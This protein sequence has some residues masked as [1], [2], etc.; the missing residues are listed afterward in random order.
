VP[1]AGSIHHDLAG[2]VAAAAAPATVAPII[3]APARTAPIVLNFI[4]F[5]LLIG[6]NLISQKGTILYCVELFINLLF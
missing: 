3:A 1:V 2:T 6:F 4:Y 5:H